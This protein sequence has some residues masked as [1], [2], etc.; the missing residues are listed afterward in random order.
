MKI[1]KMPDN[2]I[3]DTCLPDHKYPNPRKN[4]GYPIPLHHMTDLT[5]FDFLSLHFNKDHSIFT[6]FSN[7]YYYKL[8]LRT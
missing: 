8:S 4:Y 6:N 3:Y 7:S 1:L 2:V 5:D